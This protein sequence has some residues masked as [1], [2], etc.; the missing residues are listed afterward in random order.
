MQTLHHTSTF[1]SNF[2]KE[3]KA[4]HLI[5]AQAIMQILAFLCVFICYQLP[6]SSLHSYYGMIT[7]AL[8]FK[9]CEVISY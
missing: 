3:N 4:C 7:I 9:K 5:Y 8:T 2:S 1:G 6:L